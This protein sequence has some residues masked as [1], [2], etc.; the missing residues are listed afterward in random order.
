MSWEDV[1]RL[2]D[3]SQVNLELAI[4]WLDDCISYSQETRKYLEKSGYLLKKCRDEDNREAPG[5]RRGNSS[6]H[7][8]G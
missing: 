3:L 7:A 8:T 2:N 1:A 6:T 4:A 5:Q